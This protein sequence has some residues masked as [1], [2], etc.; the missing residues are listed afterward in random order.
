[1]SIEE[2]LAALEAEVQQLREQ[3]TDTHT[4]A[5]HADRDVG[6]FRSE[7]RAQTRLIN[8]NRQDMTGLR[9]DMADLRIEL[10]SLMADLRGE[11]RAGFAA[12]GR[13]LQQLGARPDE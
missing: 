2:R 11:T 3:V 9:R 10:G 6:G 12:I 5:A 7:L 8:L 4:L 13:M 1:V